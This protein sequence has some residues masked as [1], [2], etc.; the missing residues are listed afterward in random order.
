M[1]RLKEKRSLVEMSRRFGQEP[2][3]ELLEEIRVLE[4]QESKKQEREGKIKARI[5]ADLQSI[6]E[7]VKNEPVSVKD[8]PGL[9][10]AIGQGLEAGVIEITGTTTEPA[11]S[12]LPAP[13]QQLSNVDKVAKAITEAGVVAP[14]PVLARPQKDLTQE[15]KYLREWIGRIAATGPGGGAASVLTLD[16]PVTEVTTSSYTVRRNDYYVGINVDTSTSIVLPMSG[17]KAGRSLIIKDESGRCSVNNI[18]ITGTIDND[19]SGAILAIDNG[20]LHLIYRQGW[21]IV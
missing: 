19:T 13:V 11:A 20:A 10:E 16:A 14:D 15:I 4:L 3:A 17:I 2:S 1:N 5:A 18:V 8:V 12:G 21:R 7:G 9:G 6:F